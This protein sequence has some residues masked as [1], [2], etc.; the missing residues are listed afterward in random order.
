MNRRRMWSGRRPGAVLT[1]I[2]SIVLAGFIAPN[3]IGASAV[4]PFAGNNPASG[5]RTV[6]IADITDFH[7]HIER[8]AD[9]AA[10]FAVASDHNPGNMIPVSTG[11]LVGGSPYE[12]AVEQDKPTLDMARSWNLTISAVGN[13]ELDRGVDDFNQRIA[14]PSYGIDWLCAN[15]SASN[16]R[17]GGRL[18]RV[19]DY[20]IRNVNGKRIAFIGALTDKLGSVA[21]PEITKDADLSERA[22]DAVNRV[23]G[24]LKRSGTVD[25][26]VAL[27]HDDAKAA[28]QFGRYVDLVYAGHTHAVKSATTSAGAPIYEAG[29]YGR[30]MAVQD[31]VITGHGLGARVTVVNVDIGNGATSTGTDG[32]LDITGMDSHPRQ[33][34]W[35]SAGQTVHGVVEARQIYADAQSFAANVG[36]MAVGTLATGTHFFKQSDTRPKG[37]LGMLI[38]DANRATVMQRVYAG[39]RIPVI[40]FSN[41]GSLRTDTLDTNGDGIVTVREVDSLMAL[42][43]RAAYETI[44]GSDL[45]AILAEQFYRD[46]GQIRS[47]WIGISSNVSF[48][49]ITCGGVDDPCAA[50]DQKQHQAASLT[51]HDEASG[52]SRS[53]SAAK[54]ESQSILQYHQSPVR[55]TNLTI[56]GHAIEDDD[57]IIAASNSYLLQGGDSYHAFTAGSNYVELDMSYNQPLTEYLRA[58]PDLHAIAAGGADTRS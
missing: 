49:R 41:N 21:T 34:A 6:T 26:V 11:D 28:Q 25:A 9:N 43:F 45:K 12:S 27:I 56:D 17:A 55:I 57:L 14:D 40:G 16:K 32:V 39:N 33:A 31:L 29:S 23:A 42:Q 18:D 10:A 30:N 22:A 8:G 47:R 4:V 7:G 54:S 44:T 15:T 50:E 38:A 24:E 1:I 51:D 37:E 2:I 13:H 35:M 48:R 3:A 52:L 58:H 5:T 53:P 46:D 19:K 36:D 20:T